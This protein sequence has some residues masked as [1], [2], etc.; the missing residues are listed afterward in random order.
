MSLHKLFKFF[1]RKGELV[2]IFLVLLLQIGEQHIQL[3]FTELVEVNHELLPS[4][5]FFTRLFLLLF[6][7]LLLI[8]KVG[9]LG[10]LSL[11]GRARSVRTGTFLNLLFLV[12]VL[13]FFSINF[14][15]LIFTFAFLLELLLVHQLLELSD[16]VVVQIEPS[17][18]SGLN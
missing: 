4:W 6:F 12:A 11:F 10:S 13:L 8:F 18:L 16:L 2:G 17:F 5:L 9:L 7:L 14:G 15:L 3:F 1:L